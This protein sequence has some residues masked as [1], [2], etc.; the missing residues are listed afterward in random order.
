MFSDTGKKNFEKQIEGIKLAR[1]RGWVIN[2]LTV[3]GDE[4][5]DEKEQH[6]FCV[7]GVW[8]LQKH[9]DMLEIFWNGRVGDIPF[10]AAD[11]ESGHGQYKDM[12]CTERRKLYDD[13]VKMIAATNFIGYGVSIDLWAFREFI[14][15]DVKNTPYLLC[16]REVVMRFARLTSVIPEETVEFIFDM[17]SKTSA[18][19]TALYN[20]MVHTRVWK[21]KKFMADKIS[22]ACR[23]TV[24]IQVADIIARETLKRY[25]SL[26]IQKEEKPLRQS[27]RLL[28]STKRFKFR[29]LDK[30]FFDRESD[31]LIEDPDPFDPDAYIQW[32]SK[33]KRQDN[34]SNKY[35]FLLDAEETDFSSEAES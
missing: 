31:R 4:S 12:P 22:F 6:I 10:H 1:N 25:D 30:K 5:S 24:G 2:V 8:G 14:P 20:H 34:I 23:K 28:L 35:N 13:L 19:A 21:Y 17:N 11:C 16:F 27:M 15:D 3:Y 29:H 32:L 18:G 26:F 33:K 7:A 9:W